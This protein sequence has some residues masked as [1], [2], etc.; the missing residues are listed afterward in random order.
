MKSTDNHF[1]WNTGAPSIFRSKR[2]NASQ[3]ASIGR[4]N[5]EK[6]GSQYATLKGMKRDTQLDPKDWH[7]YAKA[8]P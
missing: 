7:I 6:N 4:E 3:T 8:K 5:A 1:T 2:Q